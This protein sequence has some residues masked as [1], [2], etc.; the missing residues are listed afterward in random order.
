M[1]QW[2]E[3]LPQFEGLRYGSMYQPLSSCVRTARCANAISSFFA[4]SGH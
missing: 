4:F 1:R 2:L 3:A